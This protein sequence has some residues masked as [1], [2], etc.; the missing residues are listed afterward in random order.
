MILQLVSIIFCLSMWA[1]LTPRPSHA[2][3][4]CDRIVMWAMGSVHL[5]QVYQRADPTFLSDV[6]VFDARITILSWMITI[7]LVWYAIAKNRY[8]WSEK[9]K[10]YS[11][12][13]S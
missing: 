8:H 4:R 13:F 3:C 5:L 10:E 11:K 12:S 2:M 6:I 7:L 1:C 9:R